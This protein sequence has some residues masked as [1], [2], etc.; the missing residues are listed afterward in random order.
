VSQPQWVQVATRSDIP[1]AGVLPVHPKGLAVLLIDL[2][3]EVVAIANRCPHMGCP[4][5][6]GRLLRGIL[7]CPCH[8]WS[9]RLSTGEM[10]ASSELRLSAY[11]VR[12]DGEDVSI[13]L[14]ESDE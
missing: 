11:E 3:G 6:G 12:V 7:T 10:V 5:E 13:R 14:P 9:F 8:E 1:E 4:L 2:D